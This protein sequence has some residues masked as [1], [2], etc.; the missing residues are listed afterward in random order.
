MSKEKINLNISGMTCVNCSNGIE[1][2]VKKLEGLETSK[3]NFASN[4]GEFTIDTQLL[5]KSKLIAKIKKLGYGVEED[6]KA[7]EKAKQQSYEKLKSLFVVAASLTAFI[8]VFM[9]FPISGINQYLIFALAS[10]VQFYPGGRFYTLAFKAISNKNYDM[11][12]LVALGT[13]AA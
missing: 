8:F 4:S 7:L 10:I 3:I 11:N 6:I 9:I 13:S 12:V 1:R 5:D 2:V